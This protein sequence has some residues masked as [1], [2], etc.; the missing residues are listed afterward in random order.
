M[1]ELQGRTAVIT[2]AGSG[3]GRGIAHACAAE[4]M[5]VVVA[6][7][8]S[9][10]AERVAAELSGLGVESL[11]VQVD[12]ADAASVSALAD[13]AY[14]AFGAVHLLCNNAGVILERPIVETTPEDWRWLFSVN[15]FGVVHGVQAFAPKMI[16]Q[17]VPAHIVNTG[18]IAG[19][20]PGVARNFGTYAASKCAVVGLSETLRSELAPHGIG[21][22]VIC[23]ST[24]H[25]NLFES[26]LRRPAELGGPIEPNQATADTLLT[27][28]DPLEVGRRVI[29]AVRANRLHVITHPDMRARP[30]QRYERLMRDFDVS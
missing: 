8:S 26:G 10:R 27:G 17:S 7:L 5:R 21:V 12:V 2:G 20:A 6:D 11:P 14:G 22:S 4:G 24:V 19:L 23:P 3:I 29:D 25:T 9:E 28:M 30:Q 16:A 1:D 13:R 18:S 15:V